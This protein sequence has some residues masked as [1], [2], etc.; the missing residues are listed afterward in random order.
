[1]NLSCQV[2]SPRH[3]KA[4]RSRMFSLHVVIIDPFR[5]RWRVMCE[6]EARSVW[7][8]IAANRDRARRRAAA[9]ELGTVSNT[10]TGIRYHHKSISPSRTRVF[11][12]TI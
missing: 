3:V 2:T 8:S 5:V 12:K 7:D 4:S 10:F 11:I 9:P 1:M 6:R